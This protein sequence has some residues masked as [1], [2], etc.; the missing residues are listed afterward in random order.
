MGD[1]VCL[2]ARVEP[3]EGEEA[4]R[5][6]VNRISL[7]PALERIPLLGDYTLQPLSLPKTLF[8]SSPMQFHTHPKEPRST[9]A[10]AAL[11]IQV[12]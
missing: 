8:I 12:S 1:G 4:P 10:R 3:R 5:V 11:S 6:G 2:R 9:A 7:C